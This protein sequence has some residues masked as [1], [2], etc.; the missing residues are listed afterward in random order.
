MRIVGHLAPVPPNYATL[1]PSF[2]PLKLYDN[3]RPRPPAEDNEAE[4]APTRASSPSTWSSCLGGI[5]PVE[6]SQTL[7]DAEVIQHVTAAKEAEAEAEKIR[8]G[9]EADANRVPR[10]DDQPAGR[11][12]EEA[13]PPNTTVLIKA[14][15]DAED[16]LAD[17]EGRETARRQR[18]RQRHPD[19]RSWCAPA[20]TPGR[21]AA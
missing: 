12:R 13:V 4:R 9:A 1:I 5:L 15:E 18:R 16:T 21:R 11:G 19:A 2:N 8:D 6:D 17:L 10:D 3:D 7:E 20:P 14:T